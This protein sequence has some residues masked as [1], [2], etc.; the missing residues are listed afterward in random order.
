MDKNIFIP[1][2]VSCR[3]YNFGKTESRTLISNEKNHEYTL[4]EEISS[5]LWRVMELSKNIFEIEQWC[6]KYNVSKNEINNFINDLSGKEMIIFCEYP[7]ENIGYIKNRQM[8]IDSSES[9]KDYFDFID[10]MKIWCY[11]HKYLYSLFIELTYNCNQHC[12]H[13]Y[14]PKDMNSIQINIEQYKKL[15]DDAINLGC[16]NV[17][18]SGGEATINKHFVE[19]LEYTKSKR[20]SVEI[21]TNGQTLYD[22]PDLMNKI[23]ALYPYRIG[24]S[25]YSMDGSIHDKITGISGSFNKTIYVIKKLK[26]LNINVEIKCFQLAVNNS[27]FL[28]VLKFGENNNIFVNIDL[29]LIP[30]LTGDKKPLE[31][32]LTDE[33]ALIGIFTEKSSPLYID[34]NS[35]DITKESNGFLNDSPCNAGFSQLSITPSLDVYPCCSMP[36]V[37]GNLNDISLCDIWNNAMKKSLN[38]KLYKWQQIKRKDLQECFSNDYCVYCEYCPGMGMLENGLLKKSAVQC[39]IA[40]AKKKAHGLMA[41][42][43]Q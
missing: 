43:K 21:F 27:G 10:E 11:E 1:K 6:K 3:T 2:W 38:S 14:N 9:M 40:Q 37:L 32:E 7:S 13:C 29:S 22:E 18:L 28:D 41:E 26:E 42:I 23:V 39:R 25:L 16:F 4:L 31:F 36:L 33:G 35:R 24:L 34:I 20:L 15:I 30:T 17:I 8:Q 5:N 19:I 12:I